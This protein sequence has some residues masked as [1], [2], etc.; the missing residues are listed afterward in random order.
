MNAVLYTALI[1]GTV[2]ALAL[3]AMATDSISKP[4]NETLSQRSLY[5]PAAKLGYTSHDQIGVVS[6]A[7]HRSG[8]R[9]MTDDTVARRGFDTSNYGSAGSSS[10]YVYGSGQSSPGIVADPAGATPG[11]SRY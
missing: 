3:P 4:Y 7:P 8:S 2:L 5:V 6:E 9:A 11:S 1:G 10:G